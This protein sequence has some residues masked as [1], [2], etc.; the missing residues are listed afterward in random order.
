MIILPAEKR[1]DWKYAPVML[2]ILVTLDILIFFLYQSSDDDKF[3]AAFEYYYNTDLLVNEWPAYQRFLATQ[4][5]NEQLAD[6]QALY[7]SNET[8]LIVAAI[9]TNDQFY[10]YL[11]KNS[12]LLNFDAYTISDSWENWHRKRL[13]VNAYID[14]ISALQAGMIPAELSI[15]S[16]FSYQFLHGNFMHLLGNMVFLVVCGFAVEA[17]IGPALFISLYLISGAIGG[18]LFAL[19]D[20]QSTQPLVG[21]SASISGVMAMYLGI[22]RLR[23]IEFFYWIFVFAGYF[24]APAMLIL[25]LYIGNELLDYFLNSDSNV[26]F[27]AHAGG[28]LSGGVLIIALYKLKPD[29][30]NDDYIGENQDSDPEREARARIFQLVDTMHFAKAIDEIARFSAQYHKDFDLMVLSY[31]LSQ[32]T[33][34]PKCQSVLQKLLS[35]KPHDKQQLNQL[36][37]IFEQQTASLVSIKPEQAFKLA[38]NFSVPEHYPLAENIFRHFYEQNQHDPALAILARKLA[39]TFERLNIPGKRSYYEGIADGFIKGDI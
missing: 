14:S 3:Q 26:A 12:E 17:A 24:R 35:L 20:M 28:F 32:A 34:H 21:A 5:E 4:G 25:P 27:L 30:F 38:L 10:E 1:F 11:D 9:I 2:C 13:T 16:L 22:F 33:R 37:T 15:G 7:N 36:A 8:E 29:I 18:L 39:L 6:Y 23:K 31:M 19:L